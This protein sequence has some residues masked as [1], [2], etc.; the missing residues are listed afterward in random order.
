MAER[1]VL[2]GRDVLEELLNEQLTDL[3]TGPL[4]QLDIRWFHDV[5]EVLLKMH[6]ELAVRCRSRVIETLDVHA[7][8]HHCMA[9]EHFQTLVDLAL[10]TRASG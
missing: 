3:R 1:E 4:E 7:R 5:I 2:V 8:A 6:P 9:V 10:S